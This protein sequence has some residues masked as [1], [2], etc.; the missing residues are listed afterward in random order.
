MDVNWLPLDINN[1]PSK[2]GVYGFKW[3]E[4]WLYIGQSQNIKKRQAR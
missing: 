3:R 4:T 1:I 2:P